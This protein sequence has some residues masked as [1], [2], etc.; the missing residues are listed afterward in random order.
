MSSLNF[1]YLV[2]SAQQTLKGVLEGAIEDGDQLRKVRKHI[3]KK[4]MKEVVRGVFQDITNAM[5]QD[6]TLT[7][8]GFGSFRKITKKPRVYVEPR[9]GKKIKKGECFYPKFVPS[10]QLKEMVNPA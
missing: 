2:E 10:G 3:T 8:R 7:I 1:D 6:Q 5:L 4:A 9:T